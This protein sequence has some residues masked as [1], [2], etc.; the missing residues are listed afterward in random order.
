MA[1]P[2]SFL[3]RFGSLGSGPGQLNNPWAM[4]VSANGE[5]FISQIGTV[6]A[7]HRFSAVGVFLESFDESGSIIDSPF[8]VVPAD[9]GFAYVV[10]ASANR[11]DRY[12]VS[13]VL[14]PPTPTPTPTPTP[15][16]APTPTPT[17]I[18][19]PAPKP[20]ALPSAKKCVSRRNF[21]IRLRKPAGV[22]IREALVLVNGKKIDTVRGKR[23]RAPVDLRGQP[24]GRFTVKITI[25][26]S[27]GRRLNSSRRYKTCAPKQ[28]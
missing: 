16:P 12:A 6:S 10:K 17:T 5:L 26:V 23:L 21:K 3:S 20:V 8:D 2:D 4:D 1:A 18:P 9:P 25:V 7:V 14:T 15:E 11:V 13:D 28:R 24:K 22:T 19:K 27:D